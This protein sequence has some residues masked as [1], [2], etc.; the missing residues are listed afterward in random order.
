MS[1]P[2]KTR[3]PSI[4]KLDSSAGW[5]RAGDAGL[6]ESHAESR[7]A[8]GEGRVHSSP[9]VPEAASRS[10][11]SS[12]PCCFSLCS[13]AVDPQSLHS[14]AAFGSRRLLPPGP[15][16]PSLAPPHSP[17]CRRLCGLSPRCPVYTC[18]PADLVLIPGSHLWVQPQ[19]PSLHLSPSAALGLQ[20][21][22]SHS[23]L[24]FLS[25]SDTHV[26]LRRLQLLSTPVIVPD[27]VRATPFFQ[28]RKQTLQTC[29]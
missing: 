23:Q 10:A 16:L 20:N 22:T 11:D 24:V 27:S 3:A 9:P 1:P 4:P 5:R 28:L 29:L 2:C 26:N 18:F 6:G 7:S 25:L 8:Q 21:Y 19:S 14:A 15:A 12:S 17:P 13:P